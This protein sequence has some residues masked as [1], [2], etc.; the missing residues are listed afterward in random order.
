MMV[1][2]CM[3]EEETQSSVIELSKDLQE[4][5]GRQAFESDTDGCNACG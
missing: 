3:E 4:V 5:Y 2:K 1:N